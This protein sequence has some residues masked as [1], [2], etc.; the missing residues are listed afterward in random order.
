MSRSSQKSGGKS[1][2]GSLVEVVITVGAA[3][4]LALLIQQFLVKPFH[5]P[6]V[7]MEPTILVGDRVL[8]DRLT[9]RFD[10]PERGEV[11]VFDSPRVAGEDL[12]KRVVALGGDRVAVHDGE[13][14]L[15]GE[16]QDEPYLKEQNLQGLF[17]EFVVP[18]DH[19]FAMGDNRNK[20]GDSR[21][22]GPVPYDSIL[23]RAFLIYWPPSR[24]GGL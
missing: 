4:V 11:V 7:S 3:L 20:S 9:V 6:T 12:I 10:P 8:A 23:G 14:Y 21:V 13:L 5:V 22:F 15:N 19:F 16:P 1:L 24:L 18:E 17:P 2:V